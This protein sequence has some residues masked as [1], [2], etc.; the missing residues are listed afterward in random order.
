MIYSM[1]MLIYWPPSFPRS[2]SRLYQQRPDVIS[3]WLTFSLLVY[4]N[5]GDTDED[6]DNG[7]ENRIQMWDFV[8]EDDEQMEFWMLT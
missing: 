5:H 4:Q 1:T 7:K 8:C 6:F 2:L 3:P